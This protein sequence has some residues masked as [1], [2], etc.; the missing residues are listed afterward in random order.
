[1]EVGASQSSCW[2]VVSSVPSERT[3][4]AKMFSQGERTLIP[5]GDSFMS[6]NCVKKSDAS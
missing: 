6:P 3:I 5:K 1:M 2:G 4:V